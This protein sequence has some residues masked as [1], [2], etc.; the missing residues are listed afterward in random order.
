M[1]DRAIP[2]SFEEFWPYYL[3]AHTRPSTRAFHYAGSIAALVIVGV[4]LMISQDWRHILAGVIGGYA[5][6]WIGHFFFEGNRPATFGNPFWS[7][8]GDMRMLVLW[9]TGKLAP[10]LEKAGIR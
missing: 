3:R 9:L 4:G 2:K 7:F 5:M 10:E 8:K 6:A 1:S